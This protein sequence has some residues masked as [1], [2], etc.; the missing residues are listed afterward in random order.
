MHYSIRI[1]PLWR[2]VL[3]VGGAIRASSFVELG[4]GGVRFKFGFFDTTVPYAEISSVHRGKWALLYGIGWRLGP[5]GGL[6]L[7]GSTRG[8]VDVRFGAPRRLRLLG[9][10]LRR[11]RLYVSLVRP[12]DFVDELRARLAG[13]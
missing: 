2:P 9:I 4:P 8:I 1:D 7:I 10:P 6:G 3:L 5:K 11:D 12:N 13:G